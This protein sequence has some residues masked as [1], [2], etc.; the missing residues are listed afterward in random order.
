MRPLPSTIEDLQ[1]LIDD[2]VPED[3]HLDYKRSEAIMDFDELAKDVS[4]FANSDG[5]HLIYGVLESGYKPTGIDAGV[6]HKKYK[7]ERVEDIITS[8]VAPRVDGIEIK[9]IP[10]SESSSFYAIK[11]PK[12]FRGPHQA[13]DKKYY[14]RFNFKSQPMEDYEINDVRTRRRTLQ[15]LVAVDLEIKGSIIYLIVANYGDQ[16]AQDVEFI[17]PPSIVARIERDHKSLFTRGIQYLPPKRIYRFFFGSTH[18]LINQEPP[19]LIEVSY[20]HPEIGQRTGSEFNFNLADYYMTSLNNSELHDQGEK[21][22]KSID[23][24][25]TQVKKLNDHLRNL[26]AIAGATGLDL[27]LTSLRN[28]KRI[29]SNKDDFE[30]IDPY[31]QDY[32]VFKEVLGIDF[33]MALRLRDFFYGHNEGK[34]L[35]SLDGMTDELLGKIETHFVLKDNSEQQD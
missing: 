13:P 30:K 11:V 21:V 16:T 6:D 17:L 18:Q 12:S 7:R 5:G 28:L 2:E 29:T 26:S 32:H 20:L 14:K 15:Q 4:A 9:Q 10:V 22:K 24:V 27:S 8:R 3:I 31:G 33:D 23:E 1:K 25:T 34:E 19:F 35:N